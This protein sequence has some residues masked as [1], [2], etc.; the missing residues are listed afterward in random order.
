M[1]CITSRW[2]GLPISLLESLALETPIVESDYSF[3]LRLVIREQKT[4]EQGGLSPEELERTECGWIV[5]ISG[6][7]PEAIKI[8]CEIIVE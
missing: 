5:S 3:C 2:E 4:S 8:W 1:S 6:D 7:G